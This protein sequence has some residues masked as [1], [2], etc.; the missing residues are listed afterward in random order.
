MIRILAK[1]VIHDIARF[2]RL[3]AIL[4]D[5]DQYKQ[6]AYNLLTAYCIF[7]CDKDILKEL[8]YQEIFEFLK[9]EHF[10]TKYE[11]EY[12]SNQGTIQSFLHVL[13]GKYLQDIVNFLIFLKELPKYTILVKKIENELTSLRSAIDSQRTGVNR[14]TPSSTSLTDNSC[15]APVRL[16]VNTPLDYFKQY[17]IQR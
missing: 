16:P 8:N 1:V 14:H 11:E 7:K 2:K 5:E 4:T 17:L 9:T 10:F 15:N 13:K 12:L 6:L 3:C